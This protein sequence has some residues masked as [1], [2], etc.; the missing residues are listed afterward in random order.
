MHMIIRAVV[1]AK[2]E[3][4]ALDKAKIVFRRLCENQYPFDYFTTFDDESSVMS[5]KG[6]WGARPV[7]AKADSK[8]GKQ[9]IKDDI[10][11]TF[12]GFKQSLAKIREGLK[13]FSD[14]YL[15]EGEKPDFFK[16]HCYC[17]GQY[18]GPEI[19]LYD[20]DGDGIR[21]Y[22]NLNDVLNKWKILYEDKKEDNPYRDLD[23]WVV[24]ADVHY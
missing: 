21:N 6:R 12:N 4:D 24:P 14:E 8:S 23:V 9:M 20:N 19:F 2:G 10:E 16:Y 5:G 3:E 17:A 11:Y 13:S 18:C 7:A 15:F 1:Y 22:R